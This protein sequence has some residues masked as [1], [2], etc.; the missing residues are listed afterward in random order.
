MYPTN[1]LSGITKKRKF[2]NVQNRLLFKIWCVLK[3]DY[4]EELAC[5]SSSW[6]LLLGW[7]Y[8]P[9][10]KFFFIL[11]TSTLSNSFNS[12]PAQ[13]L[14]H[15]EGLIPLVYRVILQFRAARQPPMAETWLNGSPPNPYVRLPGDSGRFQQPDIKPFR[16]FGPSSTSSLVVST[17]IQSPLIS[18]WKWW[19]GCSTPSSCY[20][21]FFFFFFTVIINKGVSC[22]R[23]ITNSEWLAHENVETT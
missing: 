18:W 4:S 9:S 12:T 22:K 14:S 17:G 23:S 19:N 6:G 20:T 21:Y 8:G 11:S 15:M 16:S 1:I 2:Q 7:R 3:V 5:G 10:T 13:D